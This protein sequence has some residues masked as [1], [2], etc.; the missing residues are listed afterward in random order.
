MTEA[1]G[2]SLWA[3]G[4]RC[5]IT[6]LTETSGHA[7]FWLV[8]GGPLRVP[9]LSVAATSPHCARLLRLYVD[10]RARICA[11]CICCHPSAL[12]SPML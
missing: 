11:A 5:P 12:H 3:P 8:A 2:L 1:E 4:V 10:W 6:H 9:E 7:V